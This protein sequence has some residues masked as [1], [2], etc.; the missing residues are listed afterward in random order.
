[1]L[2]DYLSE[3]SITAGTLVLNVH[4]SKGKQSETV[5]FLML[6]ALC[7]ISSKTKVFTQNVLHFAYFKRKPLVYV[8]FSGTNKLISTEIASITCITVHFTAQL[9]IFYFLKI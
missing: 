4:N 3:R 7:I 6:Q 8:H 2:L 1:M 5:G 9:V